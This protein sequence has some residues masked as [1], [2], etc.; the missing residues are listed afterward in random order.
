[1]K[2]K[3]NQKALAAIIDSFKSGI[4]LRSWILE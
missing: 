1:M 3:F 4:N 2:Q